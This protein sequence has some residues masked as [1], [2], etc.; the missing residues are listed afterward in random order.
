M[1]KVGLMAQ[2]SRPF[3]IALAAMALF[4]LVWLFAL[5]PHSAPSGESGSSAAPSS[6]A[7][8]SSAPGVN[9]LS[10]AIAKAH[11]AVTTSEQNAK[12]LR[13]RSAQASGEGSPSTSKASPSAPGATSSAGS[14]AATHKAPATPTTHRAAVPVPRTKSPNAATGA[15][16]PATP[17]MQAKVEAQL[18]QGKVV[19]ILFWN[20][21]AT[22]DRAVHG[23][24]KSVGGKLA[25]GVAVYDALAGQVGEFGSVIHGV[26][27]Y[28]T[29]TIMIIN[30]HGLAQTL[31]GYT[32][33]Y[34]IEQAIEEVRHA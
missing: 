23:Q 4:A 30:K 25:R 27:V 26:Q 12:Q 7:P 1:P 5:R 19:T 20:P 34:A 6:S 8:S 18:K 29:P 13:E 16:R 28:A 21:S 14:S 15:A 17:A 22:D 10:H 9:G 33:A 31:T 24:L 2:I 32:D 11:G 3:Q